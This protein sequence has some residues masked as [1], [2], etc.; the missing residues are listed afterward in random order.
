MAKTKQTYQSYFN[1]VDETQNTHL[2]PFDARGFRNVRDDLVVFVL[3]DGHFFGLFLHAFAADGV[4]P[5]FG[6]RHRPS[7]CRVPLRL[8]NNNNERGV[9]STKDHIVKEK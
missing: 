4:G 6:L 9:N 1:W 5:S 2:F 3:Q 8:S 7:Q